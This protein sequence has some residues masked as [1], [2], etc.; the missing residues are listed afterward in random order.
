MMRIVAPLA[1]CALLAACGATAPLRPKV[2]ESLPP[3]PLAART[4]PDAE[5]LMTRDDQAR[6]RRTDDVLQNSEKREPDRFDLPPPG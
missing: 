2:G 3:K 5:R 1:L 6:P 4:T